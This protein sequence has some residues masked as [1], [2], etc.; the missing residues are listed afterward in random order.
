MSLANPRLSLGMGNTKNQGFNHP[1]QQYGCRSNRK[2]LTDSSR[3]C[4]VSSCDGWALRP[5][6]LWRKNSF[7]A[8]SATGS[9]FVSGILTVVTTL[10]LQ[11]RNVLDYL[12]QACR[13]GCQG[14][15]PPS[16]LPRQLDSANADAAAA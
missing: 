5:A 14:Q 1:Q 6:V 3:F 12:T 9:L 10:R 2:C 16:L 11:Q 7:G 8:Q 4:Q 15:S 13:A